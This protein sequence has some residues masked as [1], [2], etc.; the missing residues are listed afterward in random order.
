VRVGVRGR[1]PRVS[2]SGRAEVYAGGEG[3]RAGRER[4]AL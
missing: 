1:T 3:A 2:A 4:R